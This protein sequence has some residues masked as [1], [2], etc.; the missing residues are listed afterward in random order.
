ME[1]VSSAV[2]YPLEVDELFAEAFK[3]ALLCRLC[4]AETCL[5]APLDKRVFEIEFKVLKG[6]AMDEAIRSS[7]EVVPVGR[8]EVGSEK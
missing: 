4:N 2:L 7:S 8:T 6:E 3:S 1:Q 5:K